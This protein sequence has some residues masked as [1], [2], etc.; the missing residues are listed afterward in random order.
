MS[1]E[2]THTPKPAS[3]RGQNPSAEADTLPAESNA[4]DAP[5]GQGGAQGKP[6]GPTASE[7][8]N[9]QVSPRDEQGGRPASDG[10]DASG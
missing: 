2:P 1:I 9:E 3:E 6:P 5:A 8:M 4:P 7:I 10:P